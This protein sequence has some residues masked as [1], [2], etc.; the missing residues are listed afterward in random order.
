[1]LRRVPPG[2]RWRPRGERRR[3]GSARRETGVSIVEMVLRRPYTVPAVLILI[4]LLG[5]GA[6]LRM[7][8]DIFPEIDIPVVSVVW[9]YNGMSATDM[10]N[11]ILTL[12]E[13]QLA[14]LVDDISRIEATSYTGVGVEK[15]YLHE[16]ADVTRAIS[17]LASSALVVL[18]Y[19]PP[20]ITPPL[21]LRY[22]ATDVPIIQLSLSS[23]S[24][25]DTKLNDLGQNIIRPGLA[26]VHGAE[27]PYPYGGKPRVIMADLDARALQSRGLSP[28]DVSAALAR[29][30]VILPA[31]DVKIGSKDY[32]LTMN[33]SPDLIESI[34]GFPI[35]EAG[36][37]TIF[38]RDVAR[39]HDG[40]QVQTN[41]VSVDGRPGALMSIRK[42]GGVSTLA[43]IDGIRAALPD[44]ARV[45]PPGVSIKPVFD[46]SIFVKAA[47][48]SV[49]MGGLMAAGLTALM[50]LLFLGNWRLT[51][52]I[53]AAIPL[54]IVAA[55]LVMYAGGHTLNTMTLGGFALAVGILV[56]N[57]TVVIENI[58]RH[59]ALGEPLQAAILEGTG[60]VGIPTVLSTLCICIVFVPVFLLQGTARY[61][62]SPLS[63]S[64]CVSLLASLALSFTLVPVLFKYLM[65]STLA[66]HGAAAQVRPSASAFGAAMAALRSVHARFESGFTRYRE[67]YRNAVA[68]AV[69]QPR[70][71]IAAFLGLMACSL[72]LFPFL[73]R[74]FFP[75]VD[76]GQM[77]L[78]VRAPPGTRLESTQEYFARVEARIRAIVGADQIAE[79]LDNIGLPYS[80]IN[81]ALSDTATVG[82]MD[83]EILLS[84]REHHRPT[85]AFVAQLR[86]ELP[87]DFPDLQFFFQPA[88]IVDQVLNFGQ[89]APVDVRI[90]GDDSDAGFALAS[91]IAHDLQ[92]LP[93]IVDAHVFQVPDAPALTV[94]VDRALAGE[95]GA[96]QQATADSLL[97]ATNSS[98]QLAPNFWVDPRNSVSYP[99]VVQ[100]PAYRISS[101][102]DL[103]TVPVAG[104]GGGRPP[105]LMN[106]SQFGRARQPMVVSQFNIRPVFDVHADVQGRDLESAARD[107]SRVLDADRPA[108]DKAM[109]VVLS[110]QVETMRESYAGLFTGIGLAVV[111]VYL[112]LVINF[113][114]W[115]DPLIVL[116]AVPFALGGV[117]WMLF[118][119]QTH[120]SVPALMGTLMCIGLTTANSI[121][122]VT[123]ANQ[124]MASGE[125]SRTA[126]VAAGATRLRPV[127]MTAGAMILGMIPMALGIGEGGEQNAPLARAVVGGLLFATF[128]TLV[129]VPTMYCLLRQRA[130]GLLPHLSPT[131]PAGEAP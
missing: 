68:W 27:V 55:V 6:A 3:A 95:V 41:S 116:M 2:G 121:L 1:M 82:P 108:P 76:A 24:L 115:I 98:A 106:V 13:R 123:F 93:G 39:V 97:V 17:Q 34:N 43:V 63:V 4:C 129:F 20:N 130:R 40:F 124:C 125:D 78:H 46:Q 15:V 10:Q 88:D 128:A 90:S 8:V 38:M 72:L 35:R 21:V 83:G 5:A 19:M 118:L 25:P 61:L 64:V 56:D 100:V 18:K 86:R 74:D 54:S 42:T 79:V 85:A 73:G 110:G 103:W 53:L 109:S 122:V 91:R 57:G 33:N 111:L 51:L 60:E 131:F 65:A 30:N 37:R 45:M 114:S 127:L 112:F 92:Q 52:I 31:G 70:A 26:V 119:T 104:G 113:Q 14:S 7:P 81:I 58:E 36:G 101:T 67:A 99:L 120:M 84:L 23:A 22:G 48:N 32:L 75:Q 71:V 126:A 87:R 62:F 11:R 107:I 66:A 28:A 59:V 16:G 9:T 80:G 12:H 77:R 44:L 117:M 89:P 96:S 49:V 47:L 94:D 29:Q 105:L 102:D 50:I 69:A